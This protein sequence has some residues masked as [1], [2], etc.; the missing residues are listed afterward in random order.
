MNRKDFYFRQKV[1]EAEMDAA[2]DDVESALNRLLVD[3]GFVGVASGMAVAQQVSPNLTVQVGSGVAYDQTGQRIGIVGSQNVDMTVDENAISTAVATPGNSKVLSIFAEFDRTLS[4]PRVDGNSTTIY[5]DRAETFV[6]NV[7]QGGEAVS[8]TPTA[9]RGDQI[10]LADITIA[11]GDTAITT[12]MIS[13]A[14]R[15]F[16]ISVTDT[17]HSIGASTVEAALAQIL[18]YFNDHVTG[19]AD[20][21]NATALD[22]SGGGTWADGTTNPAATVAAQLTKIIADLASVVTTAGAKRVGM[23]QLTQQ[24]YDGSFSTS[25]NVFDMFN[26]IVAVLGLDGSA[27]D[28]AQRIGLQPRNTWTNGTTNPATSVYGALAKIVDDL[29]S[30]LADSGAHKIGTAALVSWADGATNVATSLHT[31][32]DQIVSRLKATTASDSGAAK[33]GIDD[34][35]NWADA[36]TNPAGTL[37][38]TINGIVSALAGTSGTLKIGGNTIT[39]GAL[40]V[41]AGTLAAQLASM[42][43]AVDSV[44]SGIAAISSR[45][46]FAFV[47]AA[48]SPTYQSV[49]SAGS[50]VVMVGQGGALA[51]SS[52]E[53]RTWTE[54]TLGGGTP[55][56]TCVR[57]Q[58][59]D[60]QFVAVGSGGAIYTAPSATPGTWTSRTSG[61]ANA[62]NALMVDGPIRYIAVGDTGTIITSPDA[63]T[64]T[65]RTS[66][67]TNNIFSIGGDGSVAISKDSNTSVRSSTDGI[68][69][70]S[71]AITGGNMNVAVYDS[72]SGLYILGGGTSL[73]GPGRISTS[74]DGATWTSRATPSGLVSDLAVNGNTVV[75]ACSIGTIQYSLDGGLTWAAA[76][77]PAAAT[78]SVHIRNVAYDAKRAVFFAAGE[79]GI[80][81]K[82][83][84]GKRWALDRYRG[85]LS[86]AFTE[87]QY[88]T[89]STKTYLMGSTIGG[90]DLPY[91]LCV[92]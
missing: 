64:W 72:T 20:K 25:G 45:T 17:P 54:T 59:T 85:A 70:T 39:G 55:S 33:I 27:N 69:W 89:S 49:A 76:T 74:P 80:V 28:G 48:S 42:L 83:S 90:S 14:R 2:F 5:Y 47:A 7:V 86:T 61:T 56:F 75:A 87:V 4:D 79:H 50:S 32:L 67:H 73:A 24:W 41:A 11:Y 18:G 84:D 12:G 91:A 30:Q 31:M 40:T 35:A 51:Y 46:E 53:G 88:S 8:P 15:Q 1:T 37:R 29:S 3:L 52:D 21:H 43:T 6:L 34:L 92:S 82:S 62:L 81:L 57:Y 58:A 71:R 36:S 77:L 60:D 23:I 9:L 13:T 16:S 63:V 68:T 26:T 78:S 44:Y 38:A 65:T 19:S 22:Y 66:G 10:L